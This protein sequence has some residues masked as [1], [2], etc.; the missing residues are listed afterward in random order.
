MSEAAPYQD[1]YLPPRPDE[2]IRAEL[3]EHAGPYYEAMARREHTTG[4]RASLR[5]V[6]G[7]VPASPVSV[8]RL[9]RR[10]SM[11]EIADEADRAEEGMRGQSQR[12]AAWLRRYGL[13]YL[14]GCENALFWAAR[15]GD[16]DT[17]LAG[18]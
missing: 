10:P 8:A 12:G 11:E 2:E 17:P 16:D 6:L 7:E 15:L 13:G 9:D 4:Y 1:D 14:T 5:W 3:A 18:L